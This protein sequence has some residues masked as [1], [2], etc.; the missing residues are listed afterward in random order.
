MSE[1]TLDCVCFAVIESFKDYITVESLDGENKYDAGQHGLQVTYIVTNTTS[2]N[3]NY[4]I[5]RLL[6]R[7]NTLPH[8]ISITRQ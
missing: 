1:L 6:C 8:T 4:F 3:N 2:I 5:N 7:F